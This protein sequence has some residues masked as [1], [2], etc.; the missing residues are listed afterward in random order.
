MSNHKINPKKPTANNQTLTT[1]SYIAA[2][3]KTVSFE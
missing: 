1:N 3:L 2:A